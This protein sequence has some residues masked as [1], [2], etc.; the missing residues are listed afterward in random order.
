MASILGVKNGERDL[1][2]AVGAI[3]ER[4]SPQPNMEGKK[5]TRKPQKGVISAFPAVKEK[6]KV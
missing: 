3:E 6:E 2:R 4:V 1:Q 5:W